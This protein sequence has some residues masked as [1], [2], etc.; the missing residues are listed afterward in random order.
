M[1]KNRDLIIELFEDLIGNEGYDVGLDA[2]G[3]LQISKKYRS[4]GREK[5]ISKEMR[6]QTVFRELYRRPT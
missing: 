5:T 4:T 6:Q 3:G 1:S 2:G